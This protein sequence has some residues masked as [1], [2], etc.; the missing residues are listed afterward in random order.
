M[1]V[2]EAK[3][4][5][6]RAMQAQRRA[7]G[8]AQR[9]A[10]GAAVAQRILA[11]PEFAAARRVAL[12]V[13]LPDE[14]PTDAL[15]RAVLGSQRPL[16]LPRTE[17]HG[18]L[19]FAAVRDLGELVRGRFGAHAPAADAPAERLADGDLVLLPGVAFDRRGGRLGRGLGGYDR[20]LAAGGQA[21]V[22]IGLGFAFQLVEAVP[23]AAHDRRVDAV[24][25]ELEL[26]RAVSARDRAADPG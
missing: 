22:S 21:L 1:S 7:V 25:T 23:C 12:Y 19:D 18:G 8:G 15:L 14:L 17:H 11:A 2:E 24:A 20:A 9:A 13:A 10:A 6:R 3:R 5:L 16:L 4:R 26:V